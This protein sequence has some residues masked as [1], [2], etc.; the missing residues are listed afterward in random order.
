MLSTASSKLARQGFEH[1]K[2]VRLIFYVK[3]GAVIGCYANTQLTMN[4]LHVKQKKSRFPD[5]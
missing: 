2:K 3:H 5:A 1:L 4:I